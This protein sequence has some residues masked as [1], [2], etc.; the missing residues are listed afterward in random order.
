MLVRSFLDKVKKGDFEEVERAV[1]E[2]GINVTQLIDEQNLKQNALF[3]ACVVKDK[4]NS[5]RL[6]Q[7][8]LA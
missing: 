4:S 8:F 6:V 2:M 1:Q 3:S 5:L 7:Y